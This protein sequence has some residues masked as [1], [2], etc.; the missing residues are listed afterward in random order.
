MNPCPQHRQ[1]FELFG[2]VEQQSV[3]GFVRGSAQSVQPT[4][5]DGGLHLQKEV[6]VQS[7]VASIRTSS[8]NLAKG[9]VAEALVLLQ[10]FHGQK[11]EKRGPVSI[12]QGAR[13]DT[14]LQ[15]EWK[16]QVVSDSAL[17]IQSSK[18]KH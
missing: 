13:D 15:G 5:E 17:R 14:S 16:K 3:G 4:I 7:F 11:L 6:L 8:K 12:R 18:R 1:M 9:D 2:Q 10:L